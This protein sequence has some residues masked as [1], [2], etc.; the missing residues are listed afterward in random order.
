[1]AVNQ[2][3]K[4]L[5]TTSPNF[6]GQGTQNAMSGSKV[7]FVLNTIS[8]DNKIQAVRSTIDAE[9]KLASNGMTESQLNDLEETVN[10]YA[11]LNVGKYFN[12]LDRHMNKILDGSLGEQDSADD[13]PNTGTFLDHLSE[14]QTFIASIPT[15]YG[16]SA[17]SVDR[18]L[19]DHFGTLNGI[20]DSDLND[21]KFSIN[22]INNASIAQQI[23]YQTR[24]TETISYLENPGE[25]EELIDSNLSSVLSNF[26]SAASGF[27]AAL[28]SILYSSKK[29]TLQTVRN[30]I[31]DQISKE[32]NNLG[33]IRT[34]SDN[35]ATQYRYISFAENKEV[36]NL[37]V[38]ASQNNS[39][40]DYYVN[41]EER[42]EKD[43]PIYDVVTGNATELVDTVYRLK[44]YPDVQ[45]YVDL[46]S[47]A[48]KAM[49]D[50]RLKTRLKNSGKTTNDIIKDACI[51]LNITIENRDVYAQSK[52]LLEN[53]NAFDK[54]TVRTELLSH[55]T[56]NTL[57]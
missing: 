7:G 27:D 25:T 34:Y 47:V 40:K 57:S 10:T 5:V 43:N 48:N 54:E 39:W 1:M 52:S 46:D 44:G 50:S 19:N 14:V 18:G 16:T 28:D 12:L 24:C 9:T 30:K 42:Q 51:L 23:T 53:M 8:L 11:Y 56:V 15:L 55:Q 35:L 20:L 17:S 22:F 29:S 33:S 3:L 6:S 45:D 2:G 26:S 21:L 41:Y 49:R 38:R 36:S 4:T 32:V 37:I 13:R 31:L